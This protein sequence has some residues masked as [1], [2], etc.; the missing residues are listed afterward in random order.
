MTSIV[1]PKLLAMKDI[2]KNCQSFVVDCTCQDICCSATG[3]E[4]GNCG[5]GTAHPNQRPAPFTC[6][7][8]LGC[9]GDQRVCS[10]GFLANGRRCAGWW[11]RLWRLEGLG[12]CCGRVDRLFSTDDVEVNRQGCSRIRLWS[13]PR[14]IYHRDGFVRLEAASAL[15]NSCRGILMSARLTLI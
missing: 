12:F 9:L 2:Q 14:W 15:H 10:C 13:A 3:H 1:S 4:H 11:C 5:N 8:R 7:W 6:F